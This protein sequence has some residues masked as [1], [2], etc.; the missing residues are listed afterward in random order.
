MVQQA[1]TKIRVGISSCPLEQQTRFDGGHK[2]DRR[3]TRDLNEHFV[4]VPACPEV[5]LGPGAP[6]AALRLTQDA[7][8]VRMQTSEA[9]RDLTD[10]MIDYA[11]RHVEELHSWK[12]RGF[13]L[14][15]DSPSCGMGCGK[16]Y[17]EPNV[18]ECSGIGPYD[19]S[20]LAAHPNLPIDEE[21]RLNDPALLENFIIRVFAYDR[22]LRLREAGARARD[23]VNFHTRHKMLLL[24]HQPDALKRLGPL[25]ADAGQEELESTLDEYESGF[26]E[27]LSNVATRKRHVNVLQ[28][29]A[30]FLKRTLNDEEKSELHGVIADYA[31]GWVPLVAPMT[32]LKHHLR[33]LSHPWTNAQLYLEPYPR[34][35]RLRNQI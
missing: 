34:T 25:V 35:F 1:G 26:M 3:L 31:W 22:W 5:K 27:A 30:G 19:R 7:D 8:G 23:L 29:L 13:V 4:W 20:P 2:H 28:H 16:I 33:Q 6:R 17:S 10:G 24:A 14:K 32:L 12:P 18:P 11:Q 15:R 21:S 9:S